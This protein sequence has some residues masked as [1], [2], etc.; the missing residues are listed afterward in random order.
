[1]VIRPIPAYKDLPRGDNELYPNAWGV[2]GEDDQ[3][4]TINHLTPERVLNAMKSVETG[5]VVSLNLPVDA[6]DPPLIA[7]RGIPRHEIF[8]LNEFH[9]DDR[10]DNLFLQASTQLDSLRHFGHPDKGFYNGVQGEKLVVGEPDLGIQHVANKGIVG[11]GLLIDLEGFFDSIGKPIDFASGQTFSV[12]ELEAA[13]EFQ[14]SKILPGDILMIHTG[15]LKAVRRP[16]YERGAVLRSPGLLPDE[17]TAEWLWNQ[18]IAIAA[19]DNLALEAWPSQKDVLPTLAEKGGSL[20]LSSHTGML[21]RLL[22]PLLG[23]TIGELW[24]LADLSDLLKS[25]RRYDCLI[26][27][28]PLNIPGGVGSPANALAII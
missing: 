12:N 9:R 10:I 28:E 19:A 25:R 13:L 17:S 22:I 15:W 20:D 2:F 18:Q 6:F 23:I 4:G 3:L 8:G 26:T 7:H 16:G 5:Q 1:M 21:H 14:G 24:D 27:A 11:R